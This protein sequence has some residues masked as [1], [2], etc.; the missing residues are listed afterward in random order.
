MSTPTY[1]TAP[2]QLDLAPCGTVT[3][4]HPH[5]IAVKNWNGMWETNPPD[6]LGKKLN[7]KQMLEIAGSLRVYYVEKKENTKYAD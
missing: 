2:G 6:H 4:F 7:S 3:K 5:R 1:L